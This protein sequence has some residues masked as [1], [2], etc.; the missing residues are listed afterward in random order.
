VRPMRLAHSRNRSINRSVWVATII[1]FSCLLIGIW[2]A[3]VQSH[4]DRGLIHAIKSSNSERAIE[5]LRQGA[6]ANATDQSEGSTAFS[7]LAGLFRRAFR[8][9]QPAASGSASSEPT[10][11]MLVF[12][13]DHV[14]SNMHREPVELVRELL[15]RGANVNATASA[16]SWC[17]TPVVIHAASGGNTQCVQALLEHGA[18][19]NSR[20]IAGGTP[21]MYAGN[22]LTVRLLIARGADVNARTKDGSTVLRMA[23]LAPDAAV[24]RRLLIAAGARE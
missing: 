12:S 18:D 1:A 21:L 20:N 15:A 10:A 8:G 3:H 9:R 19:P 14:Q 4:M 13:P 11:L 23:A 6:D 7:R 16:D 2:R 17:R 5:L 24:R 22:I